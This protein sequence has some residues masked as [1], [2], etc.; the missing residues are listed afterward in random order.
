MRRLIALGAFVCVLILSS[1]K[2]LA[3]CGEKFFFA[4]RVVRWQQIMTAP[5]PGV[6]LMYANPASKMPA[7]LRQ[8][9]L[10]ALLKKAGHKIEVIADAAKLAD[11]IASGRYDVLLVDPADAQTEQWKTVAP[12]LV[13]VPV[14]YKPSTTERQATEKAYPRVLQA[15]NGYES[16]RLVNNVMRAR[17]H[18]TP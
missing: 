10:E 5:V 17:A 4:G 15:N 11:A 18:T 14:L 8:T 1:G 16:L 7:I 13:V 12:R 2:D 9:S 6:V 3:A